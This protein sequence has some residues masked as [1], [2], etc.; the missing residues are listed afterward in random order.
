MKKQLYHLLAFLFGACPCMIHADHGSDFRSFLVGGVAPARYVSQVAAF[1]N[2]LD[3][4]DGNSIT[5][6]YNLM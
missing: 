3:G 4:S 6:T 5:R 2:P 1:G